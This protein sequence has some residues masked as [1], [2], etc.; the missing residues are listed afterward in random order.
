MKQEEISVFQGEFSDEIRVELHTKRKECGLSYA[1]LGKLLQVAWMTVRNWEKGKIRKCHPSKVIAIRHFLCGRMD[2]L[3]KRSR[4]HAI[5][6]GDGE[7]GERKL[8]MLEKISKVY[9]LCSESDEL[10][11]LLISEII[12]ISREAIASFAENHD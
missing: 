11:K 10:R 7:K 2:A 9:D 4:S 8:E 5:E 6:R 1:Q 3:W 12:R